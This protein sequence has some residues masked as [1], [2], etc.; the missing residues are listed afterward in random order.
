M[1][2]KTPFALFAAVMMMAIAFSGCLGSGGVAGWTQD[3]LVVPDFQVVDR[4]SPELP[5]PLSPV[6]FTYSYRLIWTISKVYMSYGGLMNVSMENTGGTMIYVYHLGVE[7][8]NSTISS[9]RDTEVYIDPGETGDLGMIFFEAPESYSGEYEVHIRICV[10]NP[11]ESMW[12]D[13][14]EKAAAPRSTGIGPRASEPTN[15]SVQSNPTTYFNRVNDR[16]SYDAVG[17][18]TDQIQA[19]YSLNQSINQIVG[20]FEWVSDNIIYVEDTGGDNWQ[21]AQETLEL[22]T[23]DCED[24]AILLASIFGA[25][26]LN[27][28]VNV[29]EGHAF[30]SVFVSDD[31]AGMADV[32]EVIESMY[33][34]DLPICFLKDDMGY[35]LVTDT[36]GFFYAGGMPARAQPLEDSNPYAW[37]FESTSYLI[38]V[39]A[40]GPSSG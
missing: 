22:G 15:Y 19:E 10:S 9:S 14:G 4:P 38:T 33:W 28:R 39:D 37:T 1:V 6:N 12:H 35:W 30:A 7:W 2:N 3:D 23:G 13:Y 36:T 32:R 21:S 17:N 16:V 31:L 5:T 25:M 24:Q 11:G 20:A 26:D 29:I 8:V 40:V 27:G 18:V 34:T